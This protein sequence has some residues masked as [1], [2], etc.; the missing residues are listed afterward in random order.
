MGMKSSRTVKPVTKERVTAMPITWGACNTSCSALGPRCGD[1][2][3]QSEFETAM[4]ATPTPMPIQLLK[5]ATMPAELCAALRGW[6][7]SKD[8]EACDDG[9]R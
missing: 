4:M 1:G 2:V 3:P 8:N 5:F 7:L 6:E 9:K